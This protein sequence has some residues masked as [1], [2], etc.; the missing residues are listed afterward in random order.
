MF[1]FKFAAGLEQ[2][3]GKDSERGWRAIPGWAQAAEAGAALESG[4]TLPPR[5]LMNSRPTG[6]THTITQSFEA[7]ETL[8]GHLVQPPWHGQGHLRHH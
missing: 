3:S 7:G 2:S 8:K 6:G 1:V 5:G 4:W